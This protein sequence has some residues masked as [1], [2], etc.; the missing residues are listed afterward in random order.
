MIEIARVK[1]NGSIVERESSVMEIL[2][3]RD[4]AP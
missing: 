2:W 4:I 3:K 1:R